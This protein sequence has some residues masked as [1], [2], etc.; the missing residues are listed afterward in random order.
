M[1]LAYAFDPYAAARVAKE[2]DL[3]KAAN[4]GCY[5]IA[6]VPYV[7]TM[8]PAGIVLQKAG[9]KVAPSVLSLKASDVD[10]H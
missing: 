1:T 4:P 7:A 10:R 6:G 3:T 8:T 2:I 5:T 9:R